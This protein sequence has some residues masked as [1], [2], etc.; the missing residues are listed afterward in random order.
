VINGLD[1]VEHPCQIL[2]DLM[3]VREQKRKLHGLRLAYVGDGNNVCNSLLLGC[4]LVGMDVSVGCP[5]GYEPNPAIVQRAKEIAS[6]EGSRVL[7]TEDPREAA[8]GA[9]AIYTDVWVSM[10]MEAETEEREK[11]FRPYQVNRDLLAT[12]AHNCVVL[13]CLPAHRGLEITDEVLDGP[14][15]VVLDQAENRL[16]AQKALLVDLLKPRD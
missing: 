10:G 4:A 13:H 1:D 7:I 11:I 8:R 2:A 14:H 9:D 12:A 3:T 6:I 5:R 15:S 16:H